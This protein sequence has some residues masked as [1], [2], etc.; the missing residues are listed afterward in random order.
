MRTLE[1]L[2]CWSMAAAIGSAFIVGSSSAI[3]AVSKLNST[4]SHRDC[5]INSALTE[6]VNA[7]D[8]LQVAGG[9]R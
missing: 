7:C 9:Q 3:Q 6:T 8:A 2:V 5:V 4:L 1:T